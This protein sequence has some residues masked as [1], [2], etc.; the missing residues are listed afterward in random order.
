MSYLNNKTIVVDAVLTNIGR[1]RFAEGNFNIT[2]FALADD[3]IDYGLY[4][5]NHPNGTAYYDEAI[6]ATPILEPVVD[7]KSLM[8]N[9]LFTPDTTQPFIGNIPAV[10]IDNK[11]GAAS[12]LIKYDNNYFKSYRDGNLSTAPYLLEYGP[13]WIS[14]LTGATLPVYVQLIKFQFM[15]GPTNAEYEMDIAGQ[16]DATQAIYLGLG[17]KLYAPHRSGIRPVL[18]INE[19]VA[20]GNISDSDFIYLAIDTRAFNYQSTTNNLTF[21]L[22]WRERNTGLGGYIPFTLS[23]FEAIT[24]VID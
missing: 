22:Y 24:S 2:K 7:E 20:S 4:N 9:K 13:N 14:T 15:N 12:Y 8:K 3:E 23:G 5:F 6:L 11:P 18:V 16:Q 19:G 17:G 1:Q 21:E 10:V